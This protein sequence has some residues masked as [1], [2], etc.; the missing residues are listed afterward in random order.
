MEIEIFV[1]KADLFS[2]DEADDTS[3]TASEI[4]HLERDL[5]HHF[6]PPQEKTDSCS[7]LTSNLGPPIPI[8]QPKKEQHYLE[9]PSFG[10]SSLCIKTALSGI[11]P[12]KARQQRFVQLLRWFR[13]TMLHFQKNSKHQEEN[14]IPL[15]QGPYP[16]YY[17]ITCP[18]INCKNDRC[19]KPHHCIMCASIFN[20]LSNTHQYGRK[21]PIYDTMHFLLQK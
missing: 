20:I 11:K 19:T 17:S 10:M 14:Y 5:S 2:E 18:V 15:K 16:K 4:V 9:P 6:D 3:L 1:S 7:A 12:R 8:T 21:C 13:G